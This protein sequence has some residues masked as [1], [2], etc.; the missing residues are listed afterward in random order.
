MPSVCKVDQV[1]K[2]KTSTKRRRLE[3]LLESQNCDNPCVTQTKSQ[4]VWLL[5]EFTSNEASNLCKDEIMIFFCS[6]FT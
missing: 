1:Y 3:D 6:D 5:L 2:D 4:N